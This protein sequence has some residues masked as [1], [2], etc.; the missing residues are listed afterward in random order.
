MRTECA[1]ERTLSRQESHDVQAPVLNLRSH[2]YPVY[3]PPLCLHKEQ[4][5]RFRQLQGLALQCYAANTYYRVRPDA[6]GK[7]CFSERTSQWAGRGE[8]SLRETAAQQRGDSS[9]LLLR[10]PHSPL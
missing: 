2:P 8:A 9:E 3:C 7:L 1:D 10:L 6:L 4:E 5:R